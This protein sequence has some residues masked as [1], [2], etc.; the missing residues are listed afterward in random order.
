[1]KVEGGIRMHL[2]RQSIP[3][4]LRQRID[5]QDVVPTTIQQEPASTH[6]DVPVL[7]L[8]IEQLPV[9]PQSHLHIPMLS[10]S[11]RRPGVV[12]HVRTQVVSDLV[13]ARKLRRA[14]R[15]PDDEALEGT[16]KDVAQR[17]PGEDLGRFSFAKVHGYW[18]KTG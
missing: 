7:A 5:A 12:V 13:S 9:S 3:L 14:V 17:L 4:F 1:M 2:R 8:T 15:A 6:E 16:A 11:R 10:R 18:G